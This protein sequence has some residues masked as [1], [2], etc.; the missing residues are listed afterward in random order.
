MR[1]K[2][3]RPVA[4]FDFD[5]TLADTWRDIAAALN[6]TL[7]EAGLPQ[8]EG[9]EVRFW[10]GEGALKLLERA[11]PEA[12]ASEERLSRLYARFREHYDR[13]C[14]DTTET[15]PGVL[16]CLEALSDAE[17]A[18]A[19]NKPA[20]FLDR[21]IEGLGLKRYFRIVL[22]GDTLRAKKPSPEVVEHLL[23][24]LDVEAASVWMIGDGAI[25]VHTGR[26]AGARTIGC[27]WGLRGREELREAQPDYLVE[28]PREI[29][30]IVLGRR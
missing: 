20:R 15:Y 29:P 10:I 4:I 8:V 5:G 21:V 24:R 11:V 13:C 22:G 7:G 19:S 9:P 3:S 17:L 1:S 28:S 26:A 27:A 2:P 14:L 25:D 6:Q 23:E 18:V 16:D 12:H 30:P